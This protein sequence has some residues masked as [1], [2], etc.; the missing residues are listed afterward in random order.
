MVPFD[1]VV[2]RK[3]AIFDFEF[4]TFSTVFSQK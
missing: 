4:L 1:R 3:I 2:T